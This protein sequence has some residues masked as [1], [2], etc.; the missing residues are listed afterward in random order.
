VNIL[1]FAYRYTLFLGKTPPFSPP[2]KT[3]SAAKPILAC[4]YKTLTMGARRSC[5][6]YIP[7][8][9][10]GLAMFIKLFFALMW[11]DKSLINLLYFP[12]FFMALTDSTNFI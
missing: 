9:R 7:E 5:G 11:N 2:K 1:Y 8:A 3:A 6:Q 10:A 12:N 4:F